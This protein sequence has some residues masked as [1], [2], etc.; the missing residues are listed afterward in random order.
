[1]G[2]SNGIRLGIFDENLINASISGATLSQ[3]DEVID[4]ALFKAEE[5]SCEIGNIV[6]C[7][8]TNDISKNRDD[9][10]QINVSATR[11]ITKLK[12]QFPNSKI[13]MCAIIPRKGN[14]MNIQTH[15]ETTANVN[16]FLQKL[17]LKDSVLEYVDIYSDF[18][19]EGVVNKTM[20]DKNDSNGIHVAGEGV[21]R[22]TE[23]I[24]LYF[25][26]AEKLTD[27]ACPGTPL[28]R[29]RYRSEI[30]ITPT[31]A[32]RKTKLSKFESPSA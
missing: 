25:E 15:N 6:V 28:E 30:S 22:M 1:M 24:R 21:K 31:S 5:K 19:K 4:R 29:K 7:L 32:E 17:C 11:A 2:A 26:R 14:S 3:I 8:G 27:D 20:F 13:G 16:R 12:H 18:F 9:S 10:D 23:K